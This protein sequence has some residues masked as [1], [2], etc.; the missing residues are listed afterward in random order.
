MCVCLAMC[1]GGGI[2][3][4][5]SSPSSPG[6]HSCKPWP[7]T[8]AQIPQPGRMPH[9]WERREGSQ[10]GLVMQ[11]EGLPEGIYCQLVHICNSQGGYC[12]P[13]VPFPPDL[14][15]LKMLVHFKILKSLL[16]PIHLIQIIWQVLFLEIVF[17]HGEL[18]SL[19]TL[20]WSLNKPWSQATSWLSLSWPSSLLSHLSLDTFTYQAKSTQAYMMP[21]LS[22]AREALGISGSILLRPGRHRVWFCPWRITEK[23]QQKR[24][25][26]TKS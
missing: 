9:C 22:T 14:E 24:S 5:M 19:L 20:L 17:I 3:G 25:M 1:D 18:S 15:G 2:L 16:L 23:G 21:A 7:S 8:R 6:T 11:Q 10:T 4:I 12:A 26:V 13:R